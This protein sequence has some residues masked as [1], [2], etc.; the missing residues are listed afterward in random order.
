MK[1]IGILISYIGYFA[2]LIG[3]Q[4]NPSGFE[5]VIPISLI[6]F[7]QVLLFEAWEHYENW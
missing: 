6:T 5:W 4:F 2:I 3:G 7:F 1:W